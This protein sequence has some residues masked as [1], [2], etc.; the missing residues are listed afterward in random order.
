VALRVQ[1][2][3]GAVEHEALQSLAA[4]DLVRGR[5][6]SLPSGEAVARLMDVRPLSVDEVGLRNHG[7]LAETPLWLHVLR[8]AS[9]RQEGSRLGDV[10][11]RIVA[12][13]LIGIIK[14]DPESYLRL[15]SGS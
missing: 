13:V 12:E 6:T 5:G 2:I 14:A 9:V 10:G 1:A 7:W 15:A 3:T 4:R 8:E 11:G